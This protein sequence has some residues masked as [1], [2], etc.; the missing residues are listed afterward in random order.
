[1][2]KIARQHLPPGVNLDQML[3]AIYRANQEAFIR[4]NINLVRAGRILTIPPAE[5]AVTL[6]PQDARRLVRSHHADFNAYRARLGAIP[7]TAEATPGTQAA[8]GRIE[9]KPA[10]APEPKQDQLRLSRA[11]PQ[12]PGASAPPAARAAQ[13][14]DIAA[15]QRAL[16]EA[17]SRVNDL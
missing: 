2:G 16:A 14:D 11:D 17:Q 5:G 7:T 1:L 6:D 3:I 12:K 10:P 8:A 13:G 4:D 9:P 15:R